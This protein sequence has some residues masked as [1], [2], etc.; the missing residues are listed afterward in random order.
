MYKKHQQE[1]YTS[2]PGP[3]QALTANG[4]DYQQLMSAVQWQE[5]A[6]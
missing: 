4:Q 3:E 6:T 2:N 1:W 5:R